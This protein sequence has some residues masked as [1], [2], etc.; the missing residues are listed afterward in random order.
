LSLPYERGVRQKSELMDVTVSGQAERVMYYLQRTGHFYCDDHYKVE[1]SHYDSFFLFYIIFGRLRVDYRGS[2]FL[3][4]PGTVGFLDCREPHRYAAAE[5]LEYIWLHFQGANTAD[6]FE[7][8]W[9]IN[10]TPLTSE[11]TDYIKKQIL[12][13]QNQV[14]EVG[15]IDEAASSVK[16]HSILCGLLYGRH[17]GEASDPAVQEAMRYL[18]EHLAAPVRVPELASRLHMSASQLNRVFKNNIGQTP[19]EYLVNLRINRA[20][21]LLKDSRLSVSEIAEQ[22]GYELDT[23]FS[24][25]FRKK[26]GMTPG[27]FRTMPV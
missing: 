23:S 9:K 5:K 26:T 20:K 14:K 15:A 8:Y 17:P 16:L 2:S 27:K 25:A 1:R 24:A 10:S 7:E 4:G 22:V 19:H 12:D 18:A 6:I 3:A 13:M 21:Q 11:N